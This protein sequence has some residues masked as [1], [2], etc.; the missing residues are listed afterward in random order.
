MCIA[1][2]QDEQLQQG[3][4]ESPSVISERLSEVTGLEPEDVTR[5]I[6]KTINEETDQFRY[7]ERA[8][9]ESG[10]KLA[11]TEAGRHLITKEVKLAVGDNI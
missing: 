2:E 11:V 7:F 3:S 8:T 5:A 9:D 6:A 10:Y 1:L 4:K